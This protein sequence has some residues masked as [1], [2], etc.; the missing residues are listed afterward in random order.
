M[1]EAMQGVPPSGADQS[2]CCARRTVGA[3]GNVLAWKCGSSIQVPE[4]INNRERCCDNTSW[5]LPA[6]C[7]QP[8]SSHLQCLKTR[9][10]FRHSMS[11]EASC[12]SQYCVFGFLF[13]GSFSEETKNPH[14]VSTLN[15]R[16]ATFQ[17]NWGV[18]CDICLPP[19][20]ANCSATCDLQIKTADTWLHW[21]VSLPQTVTNVYI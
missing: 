8:K 18:C 15:C 11:Q 2:T 19:S 4:D 3:E 10:R 12:H 20:D 17:V 6:Q 16:T 13:L 1:G 9:T 14:W 21:K 5:R 7:C